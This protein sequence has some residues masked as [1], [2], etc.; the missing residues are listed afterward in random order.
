[1][2]FSRFEKKMKGSR[3]RRTAPTHCRGTKWSDVC[4]Y[5][6]VTFLLHFGGFEGELLHPS[7]GWVSGEG[8]FGQ[9][10]DPLW[11]FR[12]IYWS[13]LTTI[14]SSYG[15]S[16]FVFGHEG[17][18][19]QSAFRFLNRLC[20][21]AKPSIVNLVEKQGRVRKVNCTLAGFLMSFN[22]PSPGRNGFG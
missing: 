4:W 12:G 15:V 16:Y 5:V 1:M 19:S 17:Q 3:T 18:C 7:M 11:P 10:P 2:F 13:V 6:V 8:N 20:H 22:N 14:S 21:Q 9:P